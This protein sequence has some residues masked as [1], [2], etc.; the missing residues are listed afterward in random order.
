MGRRATEGMGKAGMDRT[1]MVRRG[2]M[3]NGRNG[4]KRI[5][6]EPL[7]EERPARIGRARPVDGKARRGR[8]SPARSS[9]EGLDWLGRTGVNCIGLDRRELD[10]QDWQGREGRGLGPERQ[11]RQD[12]HGK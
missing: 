12:R 1:A 3:R 4:V 7:G 2:L 10:R 9:V 11:E 5:V 8:I 6:E